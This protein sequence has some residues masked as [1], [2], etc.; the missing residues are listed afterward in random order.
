MK[1]LTYIMDRFFG[2]RWVCEYCGDTAYSRTR[3]YCKACC[4]VYQ[5]GIKMIRI[6]K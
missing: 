6:R 5:K 2:N 1:L 4:H 3:P